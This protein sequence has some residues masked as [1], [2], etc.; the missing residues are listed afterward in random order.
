MALLIWNHLT[1]LARASH[2][3]MGLF[4]LKKAVHHFCQLQPNWLK[5]EMLL[6]FI[7]IINF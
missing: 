5:N 4:P 2:L 7:L 1:E 3:N 6:S